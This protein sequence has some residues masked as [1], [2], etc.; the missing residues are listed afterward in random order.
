MLIILSPSLVDPGREDDGPLVK[1]LFYF[2]LDDTHACS[3]GVAGWS[4]Y[5]L[6]NCNSSD[7]VCVLR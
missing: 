3:Q 2:E 6:N 1:I 4:A 5:K 7:V